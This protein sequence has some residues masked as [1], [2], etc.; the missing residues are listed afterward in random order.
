MLDALGRAEGPL[1]IE[2]IWEAVPDVGRATVFRT[3]KL[4]L[5]LGLICRVVLENGSVRYVRATPD[6]HHHFICGR[7]GSVEEFQHPPLDDT[8]RALAEAAGFRLTGHAV[9]LYG[10]CPRCRR[11][12]APGP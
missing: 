10:V 12:E 6:H 1:T 2:E 7:C 5:D 4:L 8:I 11:D 9:E 3:V